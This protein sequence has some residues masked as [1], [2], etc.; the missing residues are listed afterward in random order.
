[1]PPHR[2]GAIPAVPHIN[3]DGR[4]TFLGSSNIDLRSFDLNHENDILL[5]NI[6]TTEAVE[7]R[8]ADYLSQSREIT[9]SQ[10]HNWNLPHRLW[11]NAIATLGPVL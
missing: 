5:Q 7:K 2:Y 9:L 4:V 3:I 8:Q 11:N 1:M 6:A 10:V